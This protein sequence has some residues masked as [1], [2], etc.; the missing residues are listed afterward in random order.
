M[1]DFHRW[2]ASYPNK[3]FVEAR[4]ALAGGLLESALKHATPYW[5]DS[6]ATSLRQMLVMVGSEL[7]MLCKREGFDHALISRVALGMEPASVIGHDELVR[8]SDAV[9]ST[10]LRRDGALKDA[11]SARVVYER[12]YGSRD[13]VNIVQFPS[14]KEAT[15]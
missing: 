12:M 7:E 2:H 14:L 15:Q 3:M 10:R 4:R 8:F 9:E 5:D 1:S 11:T 6:N 13:D